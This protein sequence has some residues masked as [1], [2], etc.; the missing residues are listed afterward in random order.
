MEASR[1]TSGASGR[2][3]E[4]QRQS[5]LGQSTRLILSHCTH[6]DFVHEARAVHSWAQC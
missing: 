2:W 4:A 3:L 5:D 6:P 1:D